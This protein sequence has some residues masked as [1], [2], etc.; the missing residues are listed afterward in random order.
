[1]FSLTFKAFVMLLTLLLFQSN[2]YVGKVLKIVFIEIFSGQKNP[3]Q[4]TPLIP[5][6]VLCALHSVRG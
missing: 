6:C 4:K 1:M 2:L 5:S 3:D